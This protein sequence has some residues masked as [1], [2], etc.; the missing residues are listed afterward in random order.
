MQ[1]NVKQTRVLKFE[2]GKYFLSSGR[3]S[4]SHY[5]PVYRRT[6]VQTTQLWEASVSYVELS[7]LAPA[8]ARLFICS[9]V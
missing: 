5:H 4:Y 3:T 6:Q 8:N 9:R 7:F 2:M 1:Q